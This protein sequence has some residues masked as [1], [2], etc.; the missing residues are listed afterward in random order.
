MNV[1]LGKILRTLAAPTL[2][3]AGLLAIGTKVVLSAKKEA[4]ASLSTGFISAGKDGVTSL[5]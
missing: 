1:G 2:M 3:T 4:D 5:M